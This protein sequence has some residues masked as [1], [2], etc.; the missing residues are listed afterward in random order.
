VLTLLGNVFDEQGV[1]N[2]YQAEPHQNDVKLVHEFLV[3][4]VR[5]PFDGPF[6]LW[7]LG[8]LFELFESLLRWVH[9]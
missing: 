2:H 8:E 7:L 9:Y 6:L 3:E 1:C 4:E 5:L